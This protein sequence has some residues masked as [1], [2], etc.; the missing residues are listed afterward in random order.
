MVTHVKKERPLAL[1]LAPLV[2]SD[3]GN[4]LAMRT[5]FLLEAYAQE[6]DVD[7][8][9]IPVAGGPAEITP[10][11]AAR[12]RR[13]TVLPLGRPDTQFSLVSNVVDIGA[14]LAAFQLYGRPSIAARLSLTVQQELMTWV[15]PVRYQLVHVSRLYLSSLAAA[16]TD[17]KGN[18]P[19][20]VVDCDEDD[21]SAYRMLG[22]LAC[23]WGRHARA[24]WFEA[25]AEAFRALQVQWLRHFDLLLAA[26]SKEARSLC[27]RIGGMKVNVLP[28]VIPANTA[29][30]SARHVQQCRHDIIFVGN[31]SYLPNIDAVMWFASRIWPRLRWSAPFPVRFVIVGSGAPREVMALAR[32]PNVVV[33]GGV[34][35]VRPFY[36]SATLTVVPIRAGGGTRIKV[37]E[38]ANYGVPIVASSLGAEGTGFRSGHELL[39]ADGERNFADACIKLLTNRKIAYRLALQARITVRRNYDRRRWISRFLAVVGRSIGDKLDDGTAHQG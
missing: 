18:A 31:M 13:A 2:P 25:E 39:L 16:W 4:G 6:F 3:H 20:L 19:Y 29:C 33:T 15:G 23:R 8:A 17:E 14:R 35:D 32:S 27:N 12:T 22:R 30:W 1:F 36:S 28:N 37:L 10:Y 34:E 26:T 11:V 5:G 24:S 9:V 38:S 21:V 7:L